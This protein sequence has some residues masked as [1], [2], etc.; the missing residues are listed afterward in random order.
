MQGRLDETENWYQKNRPCVKGE[1]SAQVTLPDEIENGHQK[2]GSCAKGTLCCDLACSSEHLTG[3]D[4]A[5]RS[6]VEESLMLR[7]C[8]SLYAYQKGPTNASKAA[9][10]VLSDKAEDRRAHSTLGSE[11]LRKDLNEIRY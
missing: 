9:V 10:D 2:N 1:R 4:R 7:N 8:A 5:R 3:R 6:K 11:S